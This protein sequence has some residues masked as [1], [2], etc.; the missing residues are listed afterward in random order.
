MT[1]LSGS[2]RHFN[3]TNIFIKKKKKS[4]LG[5]YSNCDVQPF[6]EEIIE[7]GLSVLFDSRSLP[8]KETHH[9]QSSRKEPAGGHLSD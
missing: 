3:A 8:G 5:Y 2:A 6:N 7:G 1:Q 4:P 9:D